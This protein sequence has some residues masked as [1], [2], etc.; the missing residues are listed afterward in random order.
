MDAGGRLKHDECSNDCVTTGVSATTTGV[1]FTGKN[2]GRD[3]SVVG[4]V[5][6]LSKIAIKA[7]GSNESS[8]M[9]VGVRLRT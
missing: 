7:S 4:S 9:W 2:R 1:R 8:S 6:I 3:G 5:S